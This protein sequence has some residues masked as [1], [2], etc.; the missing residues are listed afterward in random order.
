MPLFFLF[1]LIF[2]PMT[3]EDRFLTFLGQNQSAQNQIENLR[4]DVL[5]DEFV[6]L[7]ESPCKG[8]KE[9]IEE[10]TLQDDC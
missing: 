9:L 3:I 2:D 1:E 6:I 10:A 8:E 7:P 4:L 5:T